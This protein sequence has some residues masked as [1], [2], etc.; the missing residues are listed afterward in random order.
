[1]SELF[2]SHHRIFSLLLQDDMVDPKFRTAEEVGKSWNYTN[3]AFV[4]W[5]ENA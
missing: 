4:K 5:L 3:P 1:M 2:P